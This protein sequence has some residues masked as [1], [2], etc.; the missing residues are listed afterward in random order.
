MSAGAKVL[1]AF[2]CFAKR[3]SEG[4]I[5]GAEIMVPRCALHA[6]PGQ[7]GKRRR[8][9]SRPVHVTLQF[10]HHKTCACTPAGDTLKS[11]QIVRSLTRE[12]PIQV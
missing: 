2:Y 8:S 9:P 10:A 11:T 12:T 4:E 3:A 6:T 5:G 7:E 1:S